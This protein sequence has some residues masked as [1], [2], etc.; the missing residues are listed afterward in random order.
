MVEMEWDAV[1]E[2]AAKFTESRAFVAPERKKPAK[3]AEE[4]KI[5]ATE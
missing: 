1:F 5:K 2:R 4:E 3:P